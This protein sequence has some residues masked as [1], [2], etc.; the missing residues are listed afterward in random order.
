V[1]KKTLHPIDFFCWML[2]IFFNL[3]RNNNIT[4]DGD[5][6]VS[7]GGSAGAFDIQ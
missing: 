1:N 2:R 3:F 7:G 6:D 5:D 4:G